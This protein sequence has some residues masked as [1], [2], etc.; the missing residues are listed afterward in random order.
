MVDAGFDGDLSYEW[1]LLV[2]CGAS[3]FAYSRFIT[4]QNGF[5]VVFMAP[6]NQQAH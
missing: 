1:A 2:I 6:E 5:D 4:L 3:G